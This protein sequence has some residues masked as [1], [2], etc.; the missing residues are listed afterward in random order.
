MRVATLDNENQHNRAP[1]Q[2]GGRVNDKH[3]RGHFGIRLG[4]PLNLVPIYPAE[5]GIQHRR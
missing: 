4:L 2:N 3:L 5:L 1:R